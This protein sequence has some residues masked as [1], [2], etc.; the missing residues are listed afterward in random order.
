MRYHDTLM[1]SKV[2]SFNSTSETRIVLY[3][4]Y[5][6]GRI[7]KDKTLNRS[8]FITQSIDRYMLES[9]AK[10]VDDSL[11]KDITVKQLP[12]EHFILDMKYRGRKDDGFMNLARL[13]YLEIQADDLPF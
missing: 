10:S 8:H 11:A 6:V 2:I 7:V 1:I 3:N 5:D 13:V 9:I 12:M 4:G